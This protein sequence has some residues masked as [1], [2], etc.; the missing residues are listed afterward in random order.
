M[1]EKAF[2]LFQ[3]SCVHLDCSLHA[4]TSDSCLVDGGDDEKVETMARYRLVQRIHIYLRQILEGYHSQELP[5]SRGHLD[6]PCHER[7]N[8]VDKTVMTL[9]YSLFRTNCVFRRDPLV[10]DVLLVTLQLQ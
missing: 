10:I 4:S 9:G 2:L 1:Q 3:P 6:T 7:N 5:M 8:N